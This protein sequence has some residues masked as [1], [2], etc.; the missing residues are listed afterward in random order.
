MLVGCTRLYPAVIAGQ[1]SLWDINMAL[2]LGM[3]I[4]TMIFKVA[5]KCR[6]DWLGSH[7][8]VVINL[9]LIDIWASS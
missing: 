8:P 5:A 3:R 7:R 1:P 6:R 4:T 2:G 9:P